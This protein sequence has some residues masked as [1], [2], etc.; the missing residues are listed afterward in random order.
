MEENVLDMLSNYN[1]GVVILKFE[2]I[3]IYIEIVMILEIIY[4]FKNLI[5][6]KLYNQRFRGMFWFDWFFFF[7]LIGC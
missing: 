5:V 1:L 6:K 4:Y 7:E 2:V 3:E